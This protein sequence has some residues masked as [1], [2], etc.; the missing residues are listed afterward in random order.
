MMQDDATVWRPTAALAK[1]ACGKQPSLP[2]PSLPMRRLTCFVSTLRLR[3]A[4][5]TP[6]CSGQ[7]L[8]GTKPEEQNKK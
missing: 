1:S 4:M 2:T 5:M 3:C 8:R 6:P 7:N